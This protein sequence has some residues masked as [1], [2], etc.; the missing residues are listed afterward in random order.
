VD[1][2]IFI[3]NFH[4]A[5][6]EAVRWNYGWD[7]VIGYDETGFAGNADEIYRQQAWRFILSGGGLFNNLDYSFVTGYEDGTFVNQAP[8]GGSAGLRRQLAVLQNFMQQL[9]F[10]AMKPDYHVVRKA[11]GVLTFA[12]SESGKQ[13]AVY[14]DGDGPCKLS[15]ALP[16]G[17]YE[18]LWLNPATGRTEKKESIRVETPVYLMPSPDFNQDLALRLMR[19]E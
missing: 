6:S 5:Y 15:L 14:L 11:P 16:S 9:D 3:I 12:L 19:L 2:N 4:Y 13:Y 1:D 18:V 7:R 8:G 17:T 10:I